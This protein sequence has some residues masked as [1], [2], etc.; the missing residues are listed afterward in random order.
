MA[1]A[2]PAPLYVGV[3]GRGRL[4]AAVAAEVASAPQTALAWHLTR[5][6]P[7]QG[8][9]PVVI[10]CSAAAGVLPHLEWAIE[11]GKPLVIGS[12]GWSIPDLAERIRGRIPVLVAPNFSLG[13]AL[14][15]RL[16]TVLARFAAADPARDPYVIEHH[17][18][19]KHDAPSGTAALLARRLLAGCPRKTGYA[20]GG[21]VSPET[22]SVAVVRAGTTFS[23]HVVG[24]DAPGEVIELTHA[25]RSFKPYAEGALAAARWLDITREPRVYS[26]DDVAKDLLDPLFRS[27]LA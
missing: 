14:L 2:P 15:A 19:R 12:T 25:A 8:P 1:V 22:L 17:H 27:P 6:A 9:C 4:G 13:V 23:S 3:F 7:P 26:M 10:E 18:A 24:L 11:R 21:P 5:E 16:T 20:V